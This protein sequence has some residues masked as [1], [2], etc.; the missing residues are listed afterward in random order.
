M[1]DDRNARELR[2]LLNA[3]AG[4][5]D[6]WDRPAGDWDS[7]DTHS[8]ANVPDAI[9]RRKDA[10]SAYRLGSKALRRGDLDL[11]YRWLAAACEQRHPGGAFRRAVVVLRAG[12]TALQRRNVPGSGE[13]RINLVW[14]LL[15]VAARWGHQD[16]RHLVAQAGREADPGLHGTAPSSDDWQALAVGDLPDQYVPQDSEFYLELRDVLLAA[17]PL[18]QAE[19][20]NQKKSLNVPGAAISAAAWSP[21]PLRAPGLTSA[22]QQTPD[23]LRP[24][25]S[26]GAA[27]QALRVLEV[28]SRY[29]GGVSTSQITREAVLPH[30]VVSRVL[31]VLRHEGFALTLPGDAHIAGPA[32]SYTTAASGHVHLQRTLAVLRDTVDAAVYVS[33]Y[34]DGDVRITQFAAGPRTPAVT[35]W[36]DFRTAA[37]ASAVGKCLLSQLDYEGRMDHFS[38]HPAARLTSRTITNQKALFAALDSRPPTVPILD[39]QEYAVGTVCAAVPIALGS[40]AGTLALSLPVTQAHRLRQ[41]AGTLSSQAATVLLL[42][43]LKGEELFTPN[44]SGSAANTAATDLVVTTEARYQPSPPVLEQP[45]DRP[46]SSTLLPSLQPLAHRPLW[47]RVGEAGT[48]NMQSDVSRVVHA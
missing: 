25:S 47:G 24:P 21:L 14:R 42:L 17:T 48:G 5:A 1:T 40:T 29:S 46:A 20:G 41:A 36:V 27:H 2:E 23:D 4:P 8:P 45:Q 12:N 6:F 44:A 16:A 33:R 34:I 19:S 31:A 38:R 9:E 30:Q 32:L 26:L 22:A 28:I 43:L 37:H 13:Q 18:S 10:N 7:H 39:L 3:L 15:A 11:A 35:E